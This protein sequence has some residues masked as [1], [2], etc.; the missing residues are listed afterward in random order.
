MTWS[1]WS[2]GP[3]DTYPWHEHRYDKHVLCVTGSITFH[4]DA[5]D[6]VL[7]AG[8]ELDLPAGTRHSATV[9]PDGVSCEESH[10][11]VRR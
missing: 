2:N 11:K 9:G 10:A 5:G 8:D 6:T 3:G 1:Q 7:G 4:T